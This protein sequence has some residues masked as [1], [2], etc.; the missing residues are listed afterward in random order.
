MIETVLAI[1]RSPNS[2]EGKEQKI[3]QPRRRANSQHYI[4]TMTHHGSL[5][6][7]AVF[8]LGKSNGYAAPRTLVL[9]IQTH[10]PAS[11]SAPGFG[12]RN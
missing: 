1:S 8:S 9:I 2:D 3:E 6:S 11:R 4:P 5:L 10:I 7:R 12:G